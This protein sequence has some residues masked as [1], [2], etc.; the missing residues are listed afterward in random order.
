MTQAFLDFSRQQGNDLIAPRP[1]YRFAGLKAGD[2][3]CLCVTRWLEALQA[4][5]APPVY[6]KCTQVKAL[7]TLTLAQLQAHSAD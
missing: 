5:V 1:E 7:E 4:G 6:L 2:R 3:W